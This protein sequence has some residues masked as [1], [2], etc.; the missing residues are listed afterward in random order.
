MER[1]KSLDIAKGLGIILVVWGHMAQACPIKEEIYLFHMP[2][3]FIISGY[4]FRYDNIKIF[5]F[6]IKKFKSYI[7]PYIFFFI[8]AESSFIL[9][10]YFTERSDQIFIYLGMLIKPYGVVRPLWFFISIFWTHCI[11]YI[12]CI[13][14]NK[15]KQKLAIS[16]ICLGIAYILYKVDIHIPLFIDSAL[17]M[18]LF[19]HMGR[20]INK[21]HILELQ[22]KKLFSIV[23]V[24]AIFFCIAIIS[25]LDID[26]MIN[27]LG[28][29]PILFFLAAIS[30]SVIILILSK[31]INKIEY[32]SSVFAYIG[33]SSLII[34]SLHMLCFELARCLLKFP[35]IEN[36]TYWDGIKTT[37]F[38]IVCSIIIAIPLKKFFPFI[39]KP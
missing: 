34:F 6:V 16:V 1:D 4:F 35:I 8:F 15:E 20:A 29:N 30:G 36:A 18:V 21:Y 24:G 27:H 17:S 23:I 12:I 7:I 11:Y 14:S 33:R 28:H 32:V 31:Y 19:L 5:S 25:K 22:G 10:Y 26:I 37:L 13:Y 2:L 3:F 38:G 9:L 39:F